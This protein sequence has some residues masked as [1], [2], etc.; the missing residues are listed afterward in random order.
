MSAQR[1]PMQ[2]NSYQLLGVLIDELKARVISP[3]QP[4][5]PI[6]IPIDFILIHTPFSHHLT[7]FHRLFLVTFKRVL[8]F[9]ISSSYLAEFNLPTYRSISSLLNSE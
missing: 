4:C 6:I 8:K 3:L 1:Q 5:S 2:Q 7:H 9:A